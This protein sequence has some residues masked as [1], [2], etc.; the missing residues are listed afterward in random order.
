MRAARRRLPRNDGTAS[1]ADFAGLLHGTHGAHGLD[2][3]AAL[4]LCGRRGRG[5]AVPSAAGGSA[6]VAS[7]LTTRHGMEHGDV[8][9]F[10]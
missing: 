6:W 7:R 1:M 10:H 2:W 5:G 3:H 4:G 8:P 9:L